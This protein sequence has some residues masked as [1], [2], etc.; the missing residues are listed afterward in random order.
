MYSQKGEARSHWQVQRAPV[1]DLLADAID[2]ENAP[3]SPHV[4]PAGSHPDSA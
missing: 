4:K 1:N 2:P 3:S